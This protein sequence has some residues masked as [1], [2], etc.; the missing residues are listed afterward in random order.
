MSLTCTCLAYH[1]PHRYMSGHCD[2][3]DKVIDINVEGL[4]CVDCPHASRRGECQLLTSGSRNH[5]P[6]ECPEIKTLLRKDS[7]G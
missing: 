7:H 5:S 3:W 4:A 6:T 1:Y 2:G